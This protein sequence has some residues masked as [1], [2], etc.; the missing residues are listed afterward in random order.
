MATSDDI[1]A[2]IDQYI[3][4]FSAG[5][6]A[7]WI[8]LFAT[9]ATLEDPVGADVKHGHGELLEFWDFVQSLSEHIELRPGGP[10]C[11][12]GHEGA[13]PITIINDF[14]GTLMAIDAIDVMTFTDDAKIA[15]MRAYWDMAQMHPLDV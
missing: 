14:D 15:T 1:N 2:T 9:D 13:F 10:A 3:K 8:E 5:D 11:V 4:T 6:R 7:G 12:A